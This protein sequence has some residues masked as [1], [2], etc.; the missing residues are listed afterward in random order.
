VVGH[1]PCHIKLEFL[2][3]H[4]PTNSVSSQINDLDIRILRQFDANLP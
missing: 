2:E 3:T 1:K 4:E